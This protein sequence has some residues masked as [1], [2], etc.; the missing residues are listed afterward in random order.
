MMKNH[1]CCHC[2]DAH[3]NHFPLD[4]GVDHGSMCFVISTYS[5]PCE[6][7]E[8]LASVKTR[9]KN[10]STM[11]RIGRP[12]TTSKGPASMWGSTK[13]RTK[14]AVKIQVSS[15]HNLCSP[16]AYVPPQDTT[17][18]HERMRGLELVPVLRTSE[19]RRAPELCNTEDGANSGDWRVQDLLRIHCALVGTPV[20]FERLG[21][22]TP[23]RI[24]NM[25]RVSSTDNGRQVQQR[26]ACAFI[27]RSSMGGG[28]HGVVARR[29]TAEGAAATG[30]RSAFK[31]ES[32]QTVRGTCCMLAR[33]P[34][35]TEV[36]TARSGSSN[37]VG[38]GCTDSD[39]GAGDPLRVAL[40]G[41]VGADLGAHGSKGELGRAGAAGAS[42]SV[43]EGI[44]VSAGVQGT[45]GRTHHL[46]A[47]SQGT[48]SVTMADHR[49]AVAHT[50]RAEAER[51]TRQSGLER[52][53]ESSVPA[54]V[55]RAAPAFVGQCRRTSEVCTA[56]RVVV[57]GPAGKPGSPRAVCGE[58]SAAEADGTC[59]D[60]VQAACSTLSLSDE[61][62]GSHVRPAPDL[63]RR[64]T[65]RLTCSSLR[66]DFVINIHGTA[67]GAV[68]GN[69]PS[70]DVAS[71]AMLQP[72]G[73]ATV[74]TC[75]QEGSP[76]IQ[77][78][79]A[80]HASSKGTQAEEHAMA[81]ALAHGF[82]RCLRPSLR[83]NALP[84]VFTQLA[85]R[86]DVDT[87]TLNDAKQLVCHSQQRMDSPGGH[88]TVACDRH[89]IVP[90]AGEQ[91]EAVGGASPSK[92][93]GHRALQ[94]DVQLLVEQQLRSH[95]ATQCDEGG[96]AVHSG[97]MHCSLVCAPAC[98]SQ[99]GAQAHHNE[100]LQPGAMRHKRSALEVAQNS[101]VAQKRWC[102]GTSMAVV[103]SLASV[104]SLA[105]FRHHL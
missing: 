43:P 33:E 18:S 58:H 63:V 25:L 2:G 4:V 90:G 38:D 62:P 94:G 27:G 70:Q 23:T 35:S 22:E 28:V 64:G 14:K 6:S 81:D 65:K 50:S 55:G 89:A 7:A 102:Q 48:C 56:S 69:L 37:S 52:S 5:L 1:R 87:G 31:L 96:D 104:S 79:A 16:T 83:E 40:R 72:S 19:A 29:Y 73:H 44:G 34:I 30:A 39:T 17:D 13:R 78:V 3:C 60:C 68:D 54:D 103:R 21:T 32:W 42:R 46:S 82:S 41:R 26:Q 91:E 86:D 24:E 53:G 57:V 71:S 47:P 93:D 8:A 9:G 20:A 59:S 11:G 49:V 95:G 45:V 66:E 36:G 15:A 10:S 99:L 100:R 101:T 85:D 74:L 84:F 76:D 61:E 80:R 51:E 75:A 92:V 88:G 98:S 12:C 77:P 97:M 67:Q 105:G